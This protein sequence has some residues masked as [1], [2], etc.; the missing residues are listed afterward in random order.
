MNVKVGN[1]RDGYVIGPFG[2]GLRNE[3]G[4]VDWST[5]EEYAHYRH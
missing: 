2:P 3:K 1:G 5:F 4:V